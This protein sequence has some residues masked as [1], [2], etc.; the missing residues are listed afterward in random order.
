MLRVIRLVR[1]IRIVKLYKNAHK[2]MEQKKKREAMLLGKTMSEEQTETEMQNEKIEI[3]EQSN[4]GKKL[5]DLTMK[6]VIV[7]VLTMLF[8]LPFLTSSTYIAEEESFLFGLEM[9]NDYSP[10]SKPFNTTFDDY[11]DILGWIVTNFDCINDS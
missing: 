10:Y 6:R 5:S 1:L 2:A 3:P 7:V 8:T 9:I 4:V 11:V